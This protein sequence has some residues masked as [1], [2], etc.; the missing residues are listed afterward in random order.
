MV[1]GTSLYCHRLDIFLSPRLLHISLLS[2]LLLLP[3]FVYII[4]TMV[5][6]IFFQRFRALA[7]AKAL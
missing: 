4:L 3:R 5:I 6:G 2:M 7:N 1:S